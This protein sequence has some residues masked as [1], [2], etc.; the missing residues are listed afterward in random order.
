MIETRKCAAG[1]YCALSVNVDNKYISGIAYNINS[2]TSPIVMVY[3]SVNCDLS[4][5]ALSQHIVNY[6]KCN[7]LITAPESFESIANSAIKTTIGDKLYG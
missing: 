1:K 7:I 3:N 5:I 2:N 6:L 4:K